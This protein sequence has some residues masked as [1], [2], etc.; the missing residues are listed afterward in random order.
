MGIRIRR[1]TYTKLPQV[2]N[3]GELRW[4]KDKEAL[5]MS[6]V[7]GNKLLSLGSDK[8]SFSQN[9]EDLAQMMATDPMSGATVGQIFNHFFHN[10]TTYKTS[11]HYYLDTSMTFVNWLDLPSPFPYDNWFFTQTGRAVVAQGLSGQILPPNYK[12]EHYGIWTG[13]IRGGENDIDGIKWTKIFPVGSTMSVPDIDNIESTNRIASNN[14]TWKATGTGY[15][16]C[17]VSAAAAVSALSGA[18]TQHIIEF[19]VNDIIVERV[20]GYIIV[21]TTNNLGWYCMRTIPIAKNDIVKIALSGQN[22][23]LTEILCQFIPPKFVH[24]DSDGNEI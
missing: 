13:F 12:Y 10:D 11:T 4:V 16:R 20:G 7:Y 18:I 14:G 22:T 23:N 6:T 8:V 5:Y 24:F 3:E 2:V 9:L 1:G 17:Y 21:T 19:C 15:V